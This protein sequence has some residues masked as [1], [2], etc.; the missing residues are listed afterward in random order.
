[1]ELASRPLPARPGQTTGPAQPARLT[2][3]GARS[4]NSDADTE[5]IRVITSMR[6]QNETVDQR[7]ARAAY[8]VYQQ[9]YGARAATS[10][11]ADGGIPP[12]DLL[13]TFQWLAR[14]PGV[15]DRAEV[16]EVVV[17]TLNKAAANGGIAGTSP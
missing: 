16:N 17:A 11:I 14:M 9:R 15:S 2:P 5:L 3:A 1:M 6:R 8:V 4:N 12:A 10:Q 13:A 7:S